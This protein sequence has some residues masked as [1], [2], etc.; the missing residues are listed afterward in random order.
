M[1][2]VFVA[3]V[4]GLHSVDCAVQVGVLAVT[5]AVLNDRIGWCVT[6]MGCGLKVPGYFLSVSDAATAARRMLMIP[7]VESLTPETTRA[8]ANANRK[9]LSRA[10]E[11]A[12][13]D[14]TVLSPDL[15][16]VPMLCPLLEWAT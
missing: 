13:D 15:R 14:V 1:K 9:A 11:R 5:R 4:H 7:G 10:I 12:V 16:G 6:H 3:T 8:W 2:K